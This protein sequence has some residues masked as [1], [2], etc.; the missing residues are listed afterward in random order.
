ME[1]INTEYKR[2]IWKIEAKLFNMRKCVCAPLT[3]WIL[4]QENPYLPIEGFLS[5]TPTSLE[6]PISLS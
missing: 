2:W 5:K 6:I 4:D 1:K 3:C